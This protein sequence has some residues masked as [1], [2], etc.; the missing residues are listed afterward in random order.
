MQVLGIDVGGTK[1]EAATI[2]DSRALDPMDRPTPVDDGAALI[3][4]L[5][6][7][8]RK[9]IERDGD[10]EAIGIGL[11]SQIDFATTT[12]RM[13]RRSPRPSSSRAVPRATS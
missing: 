11:P 3:D 6:E 12:T 10:P 13:W 9:V 1:I 2:V 7:I 4:G 8:A 5:E